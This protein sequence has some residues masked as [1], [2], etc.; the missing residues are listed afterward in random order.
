MGREPASVAAFEAE[1]ATTAGAHPVLDAHV[2]RTRRL[3]AEVAGADAGAQ[4]AQA[5]RVVESLALALQA[6]LVVR[7]APSGMADAFV[8]AR[9]GEDRGHGYGVLPRGTDA[10]AI[11]ARH[12]GR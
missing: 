8:A 11:L 3:L 9:L 10:H 6:S 12:T 4:Q 5:R 7:H 1:L 2:V